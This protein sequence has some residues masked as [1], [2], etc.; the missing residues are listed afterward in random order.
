MVFLDV[1]DVN[2]SRRSFDLQIYDAGLTVAAIGDELR[3]LVRAFGLAE[4]GLEQLLSGASAAKLGHVA[5]GR[6][7]G[8]IPFVTLYYGAQGR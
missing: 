4:A 2:G 5:G 3:H 6:D 7:E 1:A 8:G